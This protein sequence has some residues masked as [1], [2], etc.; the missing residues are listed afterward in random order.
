MK[1]D[2][3]IILVIRSNEAP[4]FYGEPFKTIIPIIL[5]RFL[6]FDLFL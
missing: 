6:W 1:S 4:A 2:N 5:H 3:W